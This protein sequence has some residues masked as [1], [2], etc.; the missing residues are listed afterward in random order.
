MPAGP[1][2]VCAF[3]GAGAL[4]PRKALLLV[5]FIL[6]SFLLALFALGSSSA[7]AAGPPVITG[8]KSENVTET[9]ATVEAKVNSEGFETLVYLEYGNELTTKPFTL[10]ASGAMQEVSFA[11]KGLQANTTYPYHV[12]AFNAQGLGAGTG[13]SFKTLA[14]PRPPD[15]TGPKWAIVSS[16]NPTNVA[17]DSPSTEVQDITIDATGGTF[18]LR[19]ELGDGVGGLSGEIPYNATPA[20][21]HGALAATLSFFGGQL[22][23]TGSPGAYVLT[24]PP[25]ESLANMGGGQ[26]LLPITADG[27]GLTGGSHSATVTTL[28]EGR[29]QVELE[30]TTINTGGSATDGSPVT[31]SD[32]LP[33]G[34]TATQITGFDA[35]HRLQ[36][37]G[38]ITCATTPVPRC[39]FSGVPYDVGDNLN[40]EVTATVAGPPA[41]ND[42]QTLT[43]QVSVAGGGAASA[44]ADTPLT[45]SSTPA[46]FGIVPGSMVAAL[47]STQAAGHPNVTTAFTLNTSSTDNPAKN[48]SADPR[49]VQFDAPVGLVGDAV[50][51]PQCSVA[52]VQQNGNHPSACPPD[53]QI[54]TA[55]LSLSAGLARTL[56]RGETSP[57]FNIAPAPGEP[58][59]FMFLAFG[60]PVRLDTSVLSD[61]DYG[62]RVTVP[63]INEGGGDVATSVTIWGVPGE[64]NGPGPDESI[65]GDH[66]GGPSP[67]THVALL[68]SPT[69]CSEP[70]SSA[71]HIDSWLAPGVFITESAS[72]GTMSGCG[73][74]PFFTS[75]SMTPDTQQA[76][77]PAGYRFDLKVDRSGDAAPGGVA[78]PDVKNVVTTL[79]LG[80]V[81][82]PSSANGLGACRNDAGVD[83]AGAP[84]EFGLHSLHLASCSASSQVGKVQITS[85]DIAEPL[86][87]V[88]YLGEP[89]CN[90]CSPQDAQDGTMVKLLLQAKGE[91]EGGVLVKTVGHLSVNQQTGQ[92]TASFEDQ[93][94]LPFSELKL[95]FAGGPRATLANPRACGTATTTVDLTPWSTPFT[96]DAIDTSP[97][98]VTGC[99]PPQFNPTFT[100][101]TTSN[102]AGG[103]SP[104]TL[105]FGR[106]DADQ[107]LAGVQLRTPPGLLGSLANVPLCPEPQASQG[108]CGPESLLGST[109]VLTGPGAEPFLVTGGKVYLT[110]PYRG[111][112]FGLS[113]VVPAKA[114]PYTLTGTTGT[115]NV[116]VRSS[117]NID[118]TTSALTV[119]SDPL[120]TI[121]DG[122]PLQL[123]LVNVT[124]DRPGFMFNPTSCNRLGITGTLSST[125]GASA[126]VSSPFQVTNCQALKFK[127]KFTVSTSG[128]TSKV[129]GASLDARVAFPPGSQ[130]TQANIAY[131]KVALPRQLPSRLT[132]LQKACLAAVFAANPANCPAASVIGTVRVNTPVLPVQLTG[133]VYFVSHGGEAFPSLVVVLQGDGVRVD[134]VATTFISKAGITSSTFKTVPDVPFSSF[135]L[136]LPEG[137]F[138]A[139][140]AN[141]ILCKSKLAMPTAIVAQNGAEIHQSTNIAV[142]GC[143]KA[144]KAVKKKKGHKASRARRSS[145]GKRGTS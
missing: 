41:V 13:E 1:V 43:N 31:V 84:D 10:P 124:I 2:R 28:S 3:Q 40:V 24:Y 142:T 103:S 23:V 44:F 85:P 61:G 47:S 92:L 112:P 123:R 137:R 134:V 115:G 86:G 139:L 60:F 119:T 70:V 144:K 105:S 89:E 78:A 107:Y 101:G 54:G 64:H 27:S 21:V 118:P 76:G 68:T 100:A 38:Q 57:V 50:T 120:P 122:I 106:T 96:P 143:P 98:Q 87:G 102:Q 94:Q 48:P 20:E 53:T 39:T 56:H 4:S 91:G 138:S 130:G 95:T 71:F 99:Q 22:T 141:G 108:T 116:V 74:L 30:L 19:L 75:A 45:I 69:Q 77:A 117:I 25:D 37:G 135:E 33:P 79:P 46:P 131:F 9:T 32:P 29:D 129:G 82:S 11:L 126:A 93:P 63:Q 14:R 62:V 34:F 81:I 104:F 111:A 90:P 15:V 16:S 97:F 8:E 58:A 109:Q 59:A 5:S 6:V 17:P 125:E 72:L 55:T 127:P 49:D 42:G 114:G 136:Y 7:L 88:V 73:A 128:K 110:G 145:H 132:T 83:P 35:F 52:Q 121:L 133:P 18:K 66:W 26:G 80:T 12:V 67:G 140:S 36:G 65:F 51:T 113:I